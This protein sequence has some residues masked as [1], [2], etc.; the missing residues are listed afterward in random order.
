MLKARLDQTIMIPR[1]VWS[2]VPCES[3]TV[4]GAGVV[5]TDVKEDHHQTRPQ[6]GHRAFLQRG[7]QVLRCRW[8]N[9]CFHATTT[10]ATAMR[11]QHQPQPHAVRVINWAVRC[12]LRCMERLLRINVAPTPSISVRHLLHSCYAKHE[13]HEWRSIL[14]CVGG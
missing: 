4:I 3:R 14:C 7:C 12:S 13:C 9:Y 8:M 1:H 10:S 2:D 11:R 5:M 6:Y